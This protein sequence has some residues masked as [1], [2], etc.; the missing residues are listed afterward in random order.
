LVGSAID[1]S[2]FD[3][4]CEN[5]DTNSNDGRSSVTSAQQ[6]L[7]KKTI[8]VTNID[9]D[10]SV[11]YKYLVEFPGFDRVAFYND[12]CFVCFDD[13]FSATFALDEMNQNTKMKA[14]FAKVDFIHHAVAPSQIGTINSILRISDYPSNMTQAELLGI[15]E[16]LDGFLNNVQFYV[17]SCLVH[18]RNQ[19]SAKKAL[20]RLNHVTNMTAIYSI[21]GLKDVGKSSMGSRSSI[22]IPMMCPLPSKPLIDEREDLSLHH[23][24]STIGTP[25]LGLDSGLKGLSLHHVDTSF[26]KS[27]VDTQSKL[28]Q[29]SSTSLNSELTLKEALDGPSLS[30]HGDS[31]HHHSYLLPTQSESKSL[32]SFESAVSPLSNT[33]TP[34]TTHALYYSSLPLSAQDLHHSSPSMMSS[35]TATHVSHSV[36]T[37][38]GSQHYARKIDETKSFLD[39]LLHRLVALE[40]ENQMLKSVQVSKSSSG[41]S[42]QPLHLQHHHPHQNQANQ[43]ASTQQQQQGDLATS[44]SRE[45]SS[46]QGGSPFVSYSQGKYLCFLSQYE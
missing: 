37:G 6:L 42:S 24:P 28:G 18:F 38:G 36:N 9:R 32:G 5:K 34:N 35:S 26:E 41:Q 21:K 44:H 39:T 33:T 45:S 2:L 20:E 30:S 10:R 27:L 7:P 46:Y 4:I 11:F 15:L 3:L 13:T 40:Q 25:N 12:Y 22:D 19:E 31:L 8:H 16:T 17:A 43:Q 14:N 1:V 23:P 29:A